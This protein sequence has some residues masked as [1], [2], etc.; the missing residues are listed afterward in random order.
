[1]HRKAVASSDKF[2]KQNP[3]YKNKIVDTLKKKIVIKYNSVNK[4][5]KSL[6]LIYNYNLN[7]RKKITL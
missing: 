4:H 6:H 1:M 7:L 3:I 2:L 5:Q